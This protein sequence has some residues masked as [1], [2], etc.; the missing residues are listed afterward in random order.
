MKPE[1][2]RA[3]SSNQLTTSLETH[4][5]TPTQ[6]SSLIHLKVVFDFV[7]EEARVFLQGL[8][9]LRNTLVDLQQL[10]RVAVMIP[11]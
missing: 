3:T 6:I 10:H 5:N 2:K 8:S 11:R 7:L 4:K 9:E 1:E